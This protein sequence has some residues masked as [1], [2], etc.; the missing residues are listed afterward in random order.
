MNVEQ[1]IRKLKK[2]YWLD[3][4]PDLREKLCAAYR[5]CGQE[6]PQYLYRWCVDIDKLISTLIHEGRFCA[7]Q[8]LSSLKLTP[9]QSWQIIE[10]LVV[11]EE[12][13]GKVECN[14]ELIAIGQY[15]VE[16]EPYFEYSRQY[17]EPGSEA[18]FWLLET[19]DRE[20]AF[21]LF[22]S[23]GLDMNSPVS[24]QV[25]QSD[26]CSATYT[27]VFGEEESELVELA[28]RLGFELFLIKE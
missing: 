23:F 7:L 14:C 26:F 4:S 20:D 28:F 18:V 17:Y 8:Y 24:Q 1:T 12:F 6:P 2:Q 5:R 9:L 21:M 27:A 25:T 16:A 15:S 10:D 19:Y 22:S 13:S 3:P 11:E